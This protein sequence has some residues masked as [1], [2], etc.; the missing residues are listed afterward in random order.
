MI[1]SNT[2]TKGGKCYGKDFGVDFLDRYM[3][4][5]DLAKTTV[6]ITVKMGNCFYTSL[7]DLLIV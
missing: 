1:W 7:L 3:G 4:Y 5:R 6:S 2:V